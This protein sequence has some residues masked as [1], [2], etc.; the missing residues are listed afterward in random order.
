MKKLT[1][2]ANELG[3][4]TS[5]LALAWAMKHKSVSSVITGATKPEQVFENLKALDVKITPELDSRI[6]AILNNKPA[7]K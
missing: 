2:L 7:R 1:A 6:E 3:V 5:A 4:T